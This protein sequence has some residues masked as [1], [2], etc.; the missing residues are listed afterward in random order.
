M[1]YLS[2]AL[3]MGGQLL[4]LLLLL[5]ILFDS[6]LAAIPSEKSASHFVSGSFLF[7]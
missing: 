4:I 2:V 6:M 1:Q 5:L 3:H 7:I